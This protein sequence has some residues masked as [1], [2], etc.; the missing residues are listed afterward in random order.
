MQQRQKNWRAVQLNFSLLEKQYQSYLSDFSRCRKYRALKPYDNTSSAVILGTLYDQKPKCLKH[1]A[2]LRRHSNK[3]LAVCPYCGLPAGK[4]TLDHYLPRDRHAFP[5]LSV[6]SFNL[7]P[8]CFACQLAKSNFAPVLR[9]GAPRQK[10][11]SRLKKRVRE[12]L[13]RQELA[14]RRSKN[15]TSLAHRRQPHRLLHPY[16][17]RFLSNIVWRLQ[18]SNEL[19]PLATLRLVPTVRDVAQAALIGFHVRRLGIQERFKTELA[20]LVRFAI[21][22]F[23]TRKIATIA[24]AIAE[25]D[26]QLTASLAKEKTPNGVASTF[27]RAVR[28]QPALA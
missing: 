4:V 15:Q 14:V 25:A 26:I 24:A 11:T 5:H 19:E 20:H 8:A 23:R 16:F 28:D 21:A 6:F 9:L 2:E 27:F 10:I 22:T 13:L 18:P 3:K 7:V 12:K 1:I 17:D